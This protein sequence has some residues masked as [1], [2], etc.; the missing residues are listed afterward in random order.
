MTDDEENIESETVREEGDPWRPMHDLAAVNA[1]R[2]IE[3]FDET[4]AELIDVQINRHE[5]EVLSR[6][7]FERRTWAEELQVVYDQIS[8]KEVYE[9]NYASSRLA[10][11]VSHVSEP[12]RR[13]RADGRS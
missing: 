2:G 13:G 3:R 7:W 10:E 1:G 9:A 4:G 11:L 12:F 6:Y 5:V 8:S